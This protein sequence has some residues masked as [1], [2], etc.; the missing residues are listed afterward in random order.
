MFYPAAQTKPASGLG[1]NLL[2]AISARLQI[3]FELQTGAPF[4]RQLQHLKEGRL[5]IML[6]LYPVTERMAFYDFTVPYYREPL[7]VF[8]RAEDQRGINSLEDLKGLTALVYRGA[9]Y[10]K[11][12]D[13]YFATQVDIV[14]VNQTKQRVR[15]LLEHRADYFINTPIGAKKTILFDNNRDKIRMS[16]N[17][18]SWADI[19]MAFSRVSPCRHLI[20]AVNRIISDWLANQQGTLNRIQ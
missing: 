15:M 20:P 10:G 18:I 19:S 6:A 5:D 13:K 7:H 11:E 3:P 2:K 8:S 4:P 1:V 12:L 17:P 14:R 16:Q 9:S